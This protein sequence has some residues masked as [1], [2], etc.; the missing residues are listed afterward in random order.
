MGDYQRLLLPGN[1]TLTIEAPG[2]VPYTFDVAVDAGAAARTDVALSNG[3]IN[4]DGVVDAV[5]VQ[6]VVNAV[7]GMA[8]QFDA[9]VDGRGPSAT[10]IQAV[11]LRALLRASE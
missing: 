4:G 2:Y 6:L 7:L 3:D 11:I 1:H 5:D 9:D 8:V 10:D